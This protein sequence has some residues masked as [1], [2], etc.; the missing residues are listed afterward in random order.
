MEGALALVGVVDLVVKAIK[1]CHRGISFRT[2]E[3]TQSI[4][5]VMREA[6]RSMITPE[7]ITA[8]VAV[9]G[10]EETARKVMDERVR[11]CVKYFSESRISVVKVGRDL[12]VTWALG[13]A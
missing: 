4:V 12:G 1:P 8:V 9:I 10:Q 13:L 5:S 7:I 3:L 6:K 11:S 2:G